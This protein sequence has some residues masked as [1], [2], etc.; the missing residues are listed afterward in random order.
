[1]DKVVYFSA[2]QDMTEVEEEDNG[3]LPY[4]YNRKMLEELKTAGIQGP[5]CKKLEYYCSLY[6][7][8]A[9]VVVL[10]HVPPIRDITFVS[11]PTENSLQ[12]A[13][14]TFTS[15]RNATDTEDTNEMEN[16]TATGRC[17]KE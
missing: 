6:K 12:G 9:M 5:T 1:M 10:N 13:T 17:P 2:A 11:G 14:T 8:Q 15:K 4:G 3:R 16:T 7:K